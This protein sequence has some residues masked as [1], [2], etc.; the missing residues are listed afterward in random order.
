MQALKQVLILA[1]TKA[2]VFK[3]GSLKPLRVQWRCFRVFAKVLLNFDTGCM[4]VDFCE[5]GNP[6]RY[7]LRGSSEESSDKNE[8]CLPFFINNNKVTFLSC[9]IFFF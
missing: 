7:A 3:Q 9:Q 6:Q 2:V 5:V 4:G 8:L 1:V